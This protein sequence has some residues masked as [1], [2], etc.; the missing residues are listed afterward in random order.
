[1]SLFH[2]EL[3]IQQKSGVLQTI[4]YINLCKTKT[5]IHELYIGKRRKIIIITLLYFHASEQLNIALFNFFYVIEVHV[6]FDSYATLGKKT[7]FEY[8]GASLVRS[9]TPAAEKGGGCG[10]KFQK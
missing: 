3:V 2:M 8:V 4:K 9:V 7:V 6:L 10:N 1:M 5:F